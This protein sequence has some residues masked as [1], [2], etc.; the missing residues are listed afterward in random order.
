MKHPSHYDTDAKTSERMSK[1]KL[2][3]GTAEQLLAKRL[4]GMGFRY[5]KNWKKLPGT[6]DISIQKYNIAIFVDGEFWHGKDW[7]IRK[8][9]LNRNREY[10]IE[11]IEENRERDERIA[12]ELLGMGWVTLRFWEKDVLKDLDSCISDVISAI[13]QRVVEDEKNPWEQ[14]KPI[15]VVELF[16]GVGGFRLGLEHAS[17]LF[18]TIWANQWEPKD[19]QQN[20]FRC[21][22]FNFGRSSKHVCK[23]IATVVDSIP[24]HDLLVG[25]F[26]CQDY[27][28]AK[29]DAK[30]IE[31]E[32]GALW[33]QIDKVIKQRRPRCVVLENVDNLL[34]SP[35]KQPGRDFSMIL[36][37]FYET[38]YLVEWRDINA[39][40]YGQAQ[41]RRRTFIVALRNDTELFC[42][43]ALATCKE[44]ARG[45]RQF[46][47]EQ[48]VLA[49]AFPVQNRKGSRAGTF[50]DEA[51]FNS[52]TDIF[53]SM[54]IKYNNSGI[55]INGL[56]FSEEL[57]PVK[58]ESIPLGSIL[59]PDIPT[60]FDLRESDMEKWRYLKGAKKEQRVNA[61]GKVYTFSEGAVPFPDPL[62]RPARTMLTNEGTISRS[63]HV[64]EDPTTHKLRTL[65]PEECE[66]L[67]GFPTGWTAMLPQKYRYFTMG[68]ALV[69]PIV[70]MIGNEL[71]KVL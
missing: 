39:A 35:A 48:G 8:E 49:K 45:M 69:V 28:I 66:K 17:P 21:Y 37:S 57:I 36:R 50:I 10:W 60:R 5:R 62:D 58:I 32:K 26:P 31:G 25:G 23:D 52:M 3:N 55:M 40:E 47:V 30:G 13:G 15:K 16:A 9:K 24:E 51:S 44:G 7:D 38:R 4:W 14:M 41:R 68:N 65:I 63:T 29:A 19:P 27:S 54:E 1:V 43:L 6:P 18:E 56:V 34:Y 20:A 67:N 33:W 22:Q 61:E 70:T 53:S 46:L 12:K 11:K 2:K 42:S 64:V 71:I 59:E